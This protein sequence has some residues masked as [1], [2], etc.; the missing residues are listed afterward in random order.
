MQQERD[1][2][3]LAQE[4][5]EMRD[6]MYLAQDPVEGETIN[7][8]HSRGCMVDIEFMVQYLV[9]LHSNKFASLSQTTDN[10]GLINE[11]HRLGLVSNDFGQLTTSYR[12][13]HRWLHTRVLQNQSADIES[14]LVRDDID[15][16]LLCWNQVFQNPGVCRT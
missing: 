8:K 12:N 15:Q 16:V 3:D 5:L 11:L 10:I 1:P 13:F 2:A 4:I 14:R 9:L 7:L 6:K